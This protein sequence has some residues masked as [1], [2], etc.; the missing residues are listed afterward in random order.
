M[1]TSRRRGSWGTSALGATGRSASARRPP[2]RYS[3]HRSRLTGHPG[4][5]V[6]VV[7]SAVSSLADRLSVGGDHPG[8]PLQSHD[9][10][11]GPGDLDVGSQRVIGLREGDAREV[12]RGQAPRGEAT[13]A[14]EGDL[15]RVHGIQLAEV[16]HRGGDAVTDEPEVARIAAITRRLPR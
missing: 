4:L 2:R 11:L 3:Y 12:R 14:G 1:T 8:L 13:D 16:D 10:V 6:Q 9:H 15:D 7:R 5:G